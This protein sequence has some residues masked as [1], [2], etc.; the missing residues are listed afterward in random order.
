MKKS[1]LGLAAALALTNCQ[2]QTPKQENIS[3]GT[4]KECT[5]E[6]RHTLNVCGAKNYKETFSECENSAN[7]VSAAVAVLELCADASKRVDKVCN[8]QAD[9]ESINE[10]VSTRHARLQTR[11]MRNYRKFM[12]ECACDTSKKYCSKIEL[13]RMKEVDKSMA[14]LGLP[15]IQEVWEAGKDPYENLED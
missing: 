15:S 4:T 3:V 2:P 11:L 6:G 8:G 9:Y 5:M 12:K 7:V 13:D 10:M 14:D 1:V